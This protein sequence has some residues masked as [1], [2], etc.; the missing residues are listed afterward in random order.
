M[1]A[2]K[3]SLG[4]TR[5]TRT[6]CAWHV[7]LACS[8]PH[9]S[10]SPDLYE[11]H[12]MRPLCNVPITAV[13]SSGC[14]SHFIA[15]DTAGGA[16]I[17]GRNSYSQLGLDGEQFPV[18][19]TG[20]PRRITPSSLGAPRGTKFVHAATGRSHTLLVGSNGHIWAS[21]S[22]SHSQVCLWVYLEGEHCQ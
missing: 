15:I 19:H 20:N 3:T 11:P 14:S 17:W 7:V 13:F 12:V 9:A 4:G 22:N 10:N 1:S 6:T 2:R 8:R 16:W 5:S 18:F 21:G